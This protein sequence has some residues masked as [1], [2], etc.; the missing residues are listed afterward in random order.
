MARSAKYVIAGEIW[1][2]TPNSNSRILSPKLQSNLL[3]RISD[4]RCRIR[5]ISDLTNS[6]LEISK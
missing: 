5:P 3:F 1:G 4:L 2:Q 6:N